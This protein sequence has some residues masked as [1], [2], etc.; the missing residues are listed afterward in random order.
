[1]TRIITETSGNWVWFPI[2]N[3]QKGEYHHGHSERKP[4]ETQ[5]E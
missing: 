2:E 3:S 4:K 5:R 1:M